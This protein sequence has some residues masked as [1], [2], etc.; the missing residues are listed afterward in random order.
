MKYK[1]EL[2][3]SM[4]RKRTYEDNTFK[5]YALL[6]EGCAKAMQNKIVSRS[7]YDSVV[8]NDP[9][10]SLRAI[11]EHPKKQDMKCQSYW[12]HSDRYSPLNKR[13][14]KVSKIIQDNLKWLSLK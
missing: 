6:W 11:K 5:A 2:D 13:K 8:Y 7:D 14:V 12:M 10:A 1:A 9:I 3:E 4:R